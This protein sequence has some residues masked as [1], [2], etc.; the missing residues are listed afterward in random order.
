MDKLKWEEVE[1][2]VDDVLQLPED[3]RQT[4]IEERCKDDN[5]LKC[6]VTE[7]LESITESEGWLENPEEYKSGLYEE[8]TNDTEISGPDLSLIDKKIGSYTIKK[9]IG[10]GGMGSV[11]MAERTDDEFDH[12][13]AIKIIRKGFASRE[14]ILRFKREQQILAGMNH[15]G[16]AR[17]F[18]GGVTEEGYPYIIMEYINGT[19]ITE[20]CNRNRCTVDE[21]ISLFI[22]VLEAVRHAHENL[23]IH[24]DLKPGNILVTD[25]GDVKILDFGISKL[26]EEDESPVI[27]RTG[28]RLLTLKYAAPE[29][30]R[31]TNITTATDLY[32]L[33]IIFYELFSGEIPF[34]LEDK[35]RYESEQIILNESPPKPSSKATSNH[36]KNILSGDLDAIALKAIRKEPEERYRVA[37]EFLNE[38]K[39][40]Q[41]GLPVSARNDTLRYRSQKFLKRNRRAIAVAVGIILLIIG[42]AGFYTWNITQERNLARLE[43]EKAENVKNLL[44]ELF[45][46]NDPITGDGESITLEELLASGTDEI[47]NRELEPPVKIELLL[48]LATIYQNITEFEKAQQLAAES[49]N[50]AQ[51]HFGENSI[52]VADSY[53]KLGGL[54]HDLGNYEEGREFFL[55]AKKILDEQAS[56]SHP[57]YAT[58]YNHLGHAEEQLGNYDSSHSFFRKS[59]D[60]LKNQA[61]V[62]SSLFIRDIKSLARGYYRI[63]NYQKGDSLLLEALEASKSFHGED[64]VITSSI[65]GDLGMYKMTQAEYD[66]ARN[67]YNQSLQIK[68]KVYGEDGH[69]NYTA[70]LTNL[71]TLENQL[72]NYAVAESLFIKTMNIDE[73]LFGRDHPYVAMS[74]S[75]LA[76]IYFEWEDYEKAKRYREDA[77]DI[78]L[79][80]YGDDHYYLAAMYK[81][82]G[83]LL[84]AMGDYRQAELYFEKSQKIYENYQT[85]PDDSFA[86]LH[87]ERGKNYLKREEY[88]SAAQQFELAAENFKKSGYDEYIPVEVKSL[89]YLAV[90]HTEIGNLEYANI[91]MDNIRTR[92]DTTKALAESPEIDQLFSETYQNVSSQF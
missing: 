21:K 72:G 28:A 45:Q 81:N 86:K 24:R 82:Y 89:L 46:G 69:P 27:T 91:L 64:D 50:L 92:M 44:V 40:Y 74:K 88:Q 48:T 38:L 61:A 87:Y 79:D 9:K 8:I 60:V 65:L 39:N 16:I 29:Q 33:G 78:Y 47:I 55:K 49:L 37:N 53:I 32:A 70:T 68:E 77:M 12:R 1:T 19:P 43:A 13:V 30:I 59:I 3:Q 17:L 84:S 42:F 75:H 31:Q 20:Y 52:L 71:G 35:T 7:L 23:V 10:E 2:I 62:D 15:P 66:E 73:K 51:K 14:N 36:Q 18:D 85:T 22:Q 83:K 63:D 41:N 4:F 11:Y 54:E 58:L 26:L 80:A 90:S 76:S 56:E 5:K 67:Y 6:E 25:S 34:N 57:L